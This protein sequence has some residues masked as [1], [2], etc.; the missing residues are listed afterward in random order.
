MPKVSNPPAGM[1]GPAKC[2]EVSNYNVRIALARIDERIKKTKY[3]VNYEWLE[4]VNGG[5]DGSYVLVF[6]QANWPSSKT[7]RT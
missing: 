6:P 3:P 4:L 1:T 7:S 5:R 2:S